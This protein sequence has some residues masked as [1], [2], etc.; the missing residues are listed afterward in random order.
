VHATA[1][2]CSRTFLLTAAPC[3]TDGLDGTQLSVGAA[4][5]F[6]RRTYLFFLWQ[7]LKNGKSAV[8]ASG[9]QDPSTGEDVQQFAI[10][11]HTAF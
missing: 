7:Q 6:S 1:G 2:E 8:F 5:Y 3:I 11:I 4:Y 10:G 9:S